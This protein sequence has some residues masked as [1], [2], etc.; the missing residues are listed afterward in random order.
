MEEKQT[1][2]ISGIDQRNKSPILKY[3]TI[4]TVNNY[5]NEN[6]NESILE[7]VKYPYVFLGR[8]FS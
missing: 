6:I 4:G 3:K 7:P 5:D 8:K 1:D 2:K